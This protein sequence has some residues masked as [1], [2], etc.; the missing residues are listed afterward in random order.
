MAITRHFHDVTFNGVSLA[1]FGVH[2]SGSG[3]FAAPERDYEVVEVPGRSG[4]LYFDRG[5]YKNIEVTYPSFIFDEEL[6]REQ[7]GDL[8]SFLLNNI[9]YKRLEDTYHPDEYRMA[10][11]V[12]PIDPEVLMLKAAN[13]DLTF[14]CKPQRYL[15]SGEEIVEYTITEETPSRSFQITNPSLYSS[16]PLI[17]IFGTGNLMIDDQTLQITNN[18]D[19]IDIDCDL[20]DCYHESTNMNANVA[21]LSG[22]FPVLRS[23]INNIELGEGFTSIMITPRWW[24]I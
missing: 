11:F 5:R 24:T 18:T 19:Y 10:T 16:K 3:A 2:V 8:R 12:G 1:D 7:I 17:R 14:N 15:K 23:G 20:M 13:F 22:E 21:L 9:G 6:F 4:D